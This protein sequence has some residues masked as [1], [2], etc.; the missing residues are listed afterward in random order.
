MEKP[1]RMAGDTVLAKG[2]YETAGGEMKKPPLQK[3]VWEETR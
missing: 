3:A 1:V 2:L